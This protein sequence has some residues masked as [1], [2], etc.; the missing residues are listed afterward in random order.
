MPGC[1]LALAAQYLGRGGHI[2]LRG[3]CRLS[4]H[5]FSCCDLAN[6]V[7]L[8]CTF[9]PP[10]PKGQAPSGVTRQYNEKEHHLPPALTGFDTNHLPRCVS[11]CHQCFTSLRTC[12][13]L[14]IM[15]AGNSYNPRAQRSMVRLR[16]CCPF[17]EH[18]PSAQHT[19]PRPP[20]FIRQLRAEG[21][22][23]RQRTQ[24]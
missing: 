8:R 14:C 16:H 4:L 6:H 7:P 19:E 17:I 12:K 13:L 20:H 24:Q 3:H 21:L 18:P 22:I 10:G 1:G 5:H 15:Q 2:S 23:L 9:T 11:C